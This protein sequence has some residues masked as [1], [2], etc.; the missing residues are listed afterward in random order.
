MGLSGVVRIVAPLLLF[1]L[2]LGC[3][4]VN[5]RERSTLAQTRYATIENFGDEQISADQ[6][7]TLLE[8]VADI[9]KVTLTPTTP[10]I[11]VMVMPASRIADLYRQVVT[12]APH[13][14]DA[15][16]LYL[17][18]TNVV[19]IPYYSRTILGHELA[20]YLTEHYLKDTPRR[21]WERIALMVED[22]LPDTARVVARRAP[23]P[24]LVVV[25]TA[26]VPFATSAN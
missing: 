12:V 14:A 2:V 20:H 18:G 22:A 8:E 21:N 3:A 16:A 7:D 19:A 11:R 23:D 25:R 13:G 15:R 9:L 24:D 10:K 1:P 6:V 4:D 5:Y 17:P 26:F